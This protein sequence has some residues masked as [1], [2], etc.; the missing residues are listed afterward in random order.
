MIKDIQSVSRLTVATIGSGRIAEEHLRFLNSRSDLNLVAVCDR[1]RAL[2]ERACRL[3]GGIPQED[4]LSMLHRFHPQVVHILTP[5]SSHEQL[6]R[7]AATAGVRLIV[8]EKPAA[9][10]A[11]AT[12]NLI[13]ITEASGATLTE[14]HNY[15]FNVPISRLLRVSRSGALGI[16]RHVEIRMG[17]NLSNSRYNEH[18]ESMRFTDTAEGVLREFLPHFSYLALAFAPG[19]SVSHAQFRKSDT[20]TS[21]SPDYLE[22]VLDS[23]SGTSS[24]LLFESGTAPFTTTVTVQGSGGWASAD[25]QNPSLRVSRPRDVGPALSPVVDQW[26]GGAALLRG[27]AGS[28]WSKLHGSAIYAGIPLFLAETYDRFISG[29]TVPVSVRDVAQAAQLTEQ[30]IEAAS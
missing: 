24:R 25:L 10:T 14:D 13:D 6:A 18:F 12:I 7:D 4:H 23:P 22:A 2:A 15:L 26:V 30:I 20:A 28:L 9:P 1:E 29:D 16:I 11:E 17:I 8:V 19:A 21:L 27:A 3:Y 5:P